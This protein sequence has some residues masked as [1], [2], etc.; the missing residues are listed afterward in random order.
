MQLSIAEWYTNKLPD[1]LETLQGHWVHSNFSADESLVQ[2]KANAE[3]QCVRQTRAE[4]L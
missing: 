1:I 3:G 2:T 4:G